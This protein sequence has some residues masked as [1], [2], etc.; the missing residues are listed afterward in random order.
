M[1]W[2]KN[3]KIQA[4]MYADIVHKNYLKIIEFVFKVTKPQKSL[5][6]NAI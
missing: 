4:R 6:N 1:F 2:N 3:L 5:L